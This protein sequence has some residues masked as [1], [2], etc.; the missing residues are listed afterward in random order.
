[1]LERGSSSG[2]QQGLTIADMLQQTT[3]AQQLRQQQALQ[4]H[5]A[6][7][8]SEWRTVVV[9]GPPSGRRGSLGATLTSWAHPLFPIPT[10]RRPHTE[11]GRAQARSAWSL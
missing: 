11:C 8:L 9:M 2:V 1:M 5:G 4:A 7:G 10:L 6:L 3:G